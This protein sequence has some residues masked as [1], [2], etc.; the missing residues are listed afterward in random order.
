MPNGLI[1]PELVLQVAEAA[2]DYLITPTEF[3]EIM[4]TISS[5]FIGAFVFGALGML[6]GRLTEGV[7]E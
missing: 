1:T 4:G 2:E 5:I 6:M 3:S 7:R